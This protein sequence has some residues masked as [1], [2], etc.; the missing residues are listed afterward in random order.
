VC[1]RL[2]YDQKADVWSLGCIL[3]ELCTLKQPFDASTLSG[4]L[5]KITRGEYEPIPS[6]YSPDLQSLIAKLL[7]V[8]PQQR[9]PVSQ[10]LR[11][12]FLKPHIEK[13]L[14]NFEQARRTR[15]QT[16]IAAH[17]T[18]DAPT[19]GELVENRMVALEKKLGT[20]TFLLLY[21][22]LKHHELSSHEVPPEV[23]HDLRELISLEGL[24]FQQR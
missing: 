12:K 6:Q 7:Q 3:Y 23:L 14:L 15:R 22:S 19:L 4:L 9:P 24:H 8:D 11:Q 10:I 13:V 2:P 20:D 17:Q 18:G 1:Q 5:I 21:S 16:E